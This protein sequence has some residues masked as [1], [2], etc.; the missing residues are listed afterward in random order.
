M[1]YNKEVSIFIFI[2]SMS[3][4][5]NFFN[6]Y[7]Q[8]KDTNEVLSNNY[9]Y[10]GLIILFLSLM[11]FVEFL[12]HWKIEKGS[13]ISNINNIN[14]LVGIT[15]LLQFIMTEYYLYS[16][17]VFPKEA[18]VV[19]IIFYLIILYTFY[20]YILPYNNKSKNTYTCS[21]FFGGCRLSWEIFDYKYF[22][23]QLLFLLYIIYTIYNFISLYHIFKLEWSL[24]FL[25][26]SLFT[27]L[28][29]FVLYKKTSGSAW[30]FFVVLITIIVVASDTP[31]VRDEIIFLRLLYY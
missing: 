10:G 13:L 25:I 18:C 6:N 12:L 19:D 21:N 7:N 8:T 9:Y 2:I 26:I 11:Q 14:Y 3:V 20:N 1:C 22:P 4:V 30:C 28:I 31:I 17:N 15:V 29:P 24:I 23:Y 27:F 5:Y 16:T